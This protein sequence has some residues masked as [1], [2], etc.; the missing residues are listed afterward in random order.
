M[1]VYREVV[2]LREPGVKAERSTTGAG[3]I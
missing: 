3:G 2:G 1:E